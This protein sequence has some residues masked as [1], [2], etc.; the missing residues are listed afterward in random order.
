VTDV[1]AASG[2]D[3]TRTGT[4]VGTPF[5][6]SPEQAQGL[7]SLDFHSDLWSLGVVAFECLTGTLPFSAHALG[8]LVAKILAGPIPVP[9][10]AAPD[11]SLPPEIDAWMA[12]ALVR[13]PAARFGS[14]K[15]MAHAFV[16]AA[17]EPAT[18]AQDLASTSPLVAPTSSARPGVPAPLSEVVDVMGATQA[19]SPGRVSVPSRAP[20]RMIIGVLAALVIVLSVVVLVLLRR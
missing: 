4:L 16:L 6:M 13:D 3:P 14:A 10:K 18:M 12:R 8:P 17:G 9:S 11:V 15:E 1:L 20:Q 2:V 5:Y 19:L 7:K